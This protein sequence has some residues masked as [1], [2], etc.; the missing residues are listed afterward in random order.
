LIIIKEYNEIMWT[1]IS[2]NWKKMK[3]EHKN[4]DIPLDAAYTAPGPHTITPAVDEI[5][6]ML[7]LPD[8]FKSG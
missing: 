2:H 6:T 7:P 1:L 3:C 8:D 4:I 5:E